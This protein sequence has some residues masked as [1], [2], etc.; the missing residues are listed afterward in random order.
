MPRTAARVAEHALRSCHLTNEKGVD[1]CLLP[2][3]PAARRPPTTSA[4]PGAANS[5]GDSNR[6]ARSALPSAP[7]AQ[8]RPRSGR[9]PHVMRRAELEQVG[10]T[11]VRAVNRARPAETI[12]QTPGGPRGHRF[13]SCRPDGRRPA[14]TGPKPRS[15]GLSGVPPYPDRSA[16]HTTHGSVTR[17]LFRASCSA[18]LRMFSQRD[19]SSVGTRGK[20]CSC[21]RNSVRFLPNRAPQRGYGRRNQAAPSR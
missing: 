6:H 18:D 19:G 2:E 7:S 16:A 17:A 9:G 20:R 11:R 10:R 1:P 4:S 12:S 8:G 5:N 3:L 14:D 15:A 13:K 21:Y